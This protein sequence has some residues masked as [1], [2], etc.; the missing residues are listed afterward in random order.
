MVARYLLFALFLLCANAH[1]QLVRHAATIDELVIT[2]GCVLED[3]LYSGDTS[4]TL[5]LV[6][7]EDLDICTIESADDYDV[8]VKEVAILSP[9]VRKIADGA[10]GQS[11]LE[12]IVFNEGLESIG[13]AAFLRS[14]LKSVKFPSTLKSIGD[15][16]FSELDLGVV[17][18]PPYCSSVGT[19][20][21][22]FSKVTGVG[23]PTVDFYNFRG[24][25]H[26]DIK[27]LHVPSNVKSLGKYAFSH[28]PI[29]NLTFSEGI[30]SI[31]NFAFASCLD[32]CGDKNDS[33]FSNVKFP[34]SLRY[35]GERAFD[36]SPML[37]DVDFGDGVE[38]I[39]WR[40]FAACPLLAEVSFPSS[41]KTLRK[42]AFKDCTS[43]RKVSFKEGLEAIKEFAFENCQLS[44]EIVLPG[45][46]R[47][48]GDYSFACV[49][50]C[51]DVHFVL[52]AG[53]SEI[54]SR[55]FYHVQN[56]LNP[57]SV[58]LPTTLRL[59]DEKAFL[60]TAL[61]TTQ[62]PQVNEKG[63]KM[64]WDAYH[65][66]TLYAENVKSIGGS[67]DFGNSID[68]SCSYVATVISDSSKPTSLRDPKQSRDVRYAIYTLSGNLVSTNDSQSEQLP[69]GIYI[70]KNLTTGESGM[71]LKK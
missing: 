40:A 29:E 8:V 63:E 20:S 11:E 44:G 33:R 62:L 50:F 55:A 48:V 13:R 34:S 39:A 21:F 38:C 26:N 14:Q 23:W 7:P 66:G 56:N 64:R 10:W 58:S 59:I 45:S 57:V 5:S 17:N 49:D 16:A 18:L 43:L 6:L 71:F 28:N 35:I 2:D 54:G 70:K 65:D 41:L 60:Y 24:F 61:Q 37:K 30:D 9:S 27:E 67:P 52:S 25:Y 19:L 68:A 1:A 53:I 32:V 46:L 12:N 3:F 22:H 31:G 4:D 51:D 47:K 69:A 15:L 42:E 36:S